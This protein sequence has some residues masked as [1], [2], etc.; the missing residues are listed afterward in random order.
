M[1]RKG[2][3]KT[4]DDQLFKEAAS[5]L[6]PP[7]SEQGTKPHELARAAR[8]FSMAGTMTKDEARFV[9]LQEAEREAE[10][11]PLHLRATVGD[12]CKILR[13]WGELEIADQ[14]EGNPNALWDSLVE[15]RRW[16]DVEIERLKTELGRHG[17]FDA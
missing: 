11:G 17:E 12:V 9:I 16:F 13:R 5:I 14:Y 2:D 8:L 6:G 15:V 1:K 4:P 7:D 3:R 10:G